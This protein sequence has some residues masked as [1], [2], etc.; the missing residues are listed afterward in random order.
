MV[1][2]NAIGAIVLLLRFLGG[3][4]KNK[5][6]THQQILNTEVELLEEEKIII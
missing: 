1:A 6:I 2:G 5:G 4:W 3:K